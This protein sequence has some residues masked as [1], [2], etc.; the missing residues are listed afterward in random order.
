MALRNSLEDYSQCWQSSDDHRNG[1][2]KPRPNEG[3]GIIPSRVHRMRKGDQVLEPDTRRDGNED[4][5]IEHDYDADLGSPRHI[6]S[7]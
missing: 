5:Q 1:D 3:I 2:L 6:E 4:A 7:V